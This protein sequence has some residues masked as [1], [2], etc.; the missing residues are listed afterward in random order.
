MYV[1][2]PKAI[3][4]MITPKQRLT[5]QLFNIVLQSPFVLGSGPLSHNGTGMIRAHRAGAG[6]VT[7]KTIRDIP[8]DNPFP[9]IAASGRDSM[10][11]AEK[12]SDITGEAWVKDEI[13]RAK[14][15]GVVVIGSIGHTSTEVE[16]W[17]AKVDAA[18]ADMIELVSYQ[19]EDLA[20]MVRLAKTL[21]D[22]PILAKLS[23]NWSNPVASAR[24]VLAAGADGITAMD[25]IGPVLRIDIETGRP[26]TGGAKG[27]G[28]LTGGAIKPV[29]LR[30]V[31]EIAEFCNKPIIGIGGVMTAEDALEMLMAGASAVGICTAPMLKGIDYISK[32]NEGLAVLLERLRYED[33][34]AA[35]GFSLPFLRE[36]EE[37]SRFAFTFDPELCTACMMC[38]RSCPYESRHLKDKVMSLDE[39]C[40]YCGLCASVCPT[41][42]LRTRSKHANGDP[43]TNRDQPRPNGEGR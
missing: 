42:A 28:W 26:I 27:F 8:A 2:V 6:A 13:P 3:N 40:R 5:T 20:P 21:S 37:H 35:S 31:A 18:G 25:S 38:V 43:G 4:A 34:A 22:K 41:G 10:I 1:H 29:A 39:S 19:Q 30:Y 17:I 16:H 36:S 9:H 7:T 32:L 23:P 15:S 33:I 14:A 12:W 11:N 24:D